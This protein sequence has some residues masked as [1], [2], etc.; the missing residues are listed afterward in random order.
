MY[1]C[2]LLVYRNTVDKNEHACLFSDLTFL[3]SI[4]SFPIKYTV[5][6]RVFVD[7]QIEYIPLRYIFLSSLNKKSVL[8][9]VECFFWMIDMIWF[10]NPHPRIYLLI[11]ERKGERERVREWAMWAETSISYLPHILQPR[12]NE[13]AT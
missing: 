1:T 2:S 3:E 11:L 6:F 5:S 10:L 7:V 8:T 9:F 4:W 12:L 13:P